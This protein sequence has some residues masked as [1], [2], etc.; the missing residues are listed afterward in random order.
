MAAWWGIISE[1]SRLTVSHDD[2]AFIYAD[3][4]KARQKMAELIQKYPQ[5]DFSIVQMRIR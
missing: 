2:R 4:D 3:K 5:K 1:G